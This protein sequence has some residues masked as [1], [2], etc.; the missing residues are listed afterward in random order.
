ME[1]ACALKRKVVGDVSAGV[2]LLRWLCAHVSANLHGFPCNS[3]L[4]GVANLM[5]GVMAVGMFGDRTG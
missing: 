5:T 1:V 4:S 2:K 3:S